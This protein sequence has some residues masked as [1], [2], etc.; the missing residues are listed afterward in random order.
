ML[1]P[2]PLATPR[3]C[4]LLVWLEELSKRL[5][6]QMYLASP[7]V[8]LHPETL[9]LCLF[10]QAVGMCMCPQAGGMCMCPQA[11]GMRTALPWHG[12]RARAS[13]SPPAPF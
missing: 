8:P 12:G 7:I 10:P 1:R 9:G 13:S 2:V 11:G 4:D 5:E 3:G 6:S